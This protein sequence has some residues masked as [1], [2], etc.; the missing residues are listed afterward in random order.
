MIS[1]YFVERQYDYLEIYDGSTTRSSVIGKYSGRV[2]VPTIISSS[3]SVTI[4]FVSDSSFS[5]NGFMLYYRQTLEQGK[6]HTVLAFL[7]FLRGSRH[8]DNNSF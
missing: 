5:A 1:V 2:A 4:K 6:H 7:A 8:T 3:S